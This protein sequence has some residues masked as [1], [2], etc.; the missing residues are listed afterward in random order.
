MRNFCQIKSRKLQ[1][2]LRDFLIL[3]KHSVN[4]LSTQENLVSLFYEIAK[5]FI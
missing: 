3:S 1:R 4:K 5:S 2:D